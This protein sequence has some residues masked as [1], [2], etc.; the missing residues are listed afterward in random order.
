E[1]ETPVASGSGTLESDLRQL[2]RT[3]A[4]ASLSTFCLGYNTGIVAGAQAGLQQDP[5]FGVL[6][7]SLADGELV[8]CALLG[9]A[10]GAV[11]GQFANLV[12]RR[13]MLLAVAVVFLISPIAMALSPDFVSLLAARTMSGMSIGVSSVLV[14]LYITEVSPA[15]CRGRLGGWAPFIGTT[16]I[17]V[18]YVVSSLLGPLTYGAWR[19][20]FGLASVPA[21]CILILQGSIPET[22]RWL[23][24]QSRRGEA[25]ES[26]ARLFP[27]ASEESLE[28]ELQRIEAELSHSMQ[29]NS[30]S[31]IGL[32]KTHRMPTFIGMSINIL[33]QVSGIN[34]F[35]YFAPEIL[36]EA[37]FGN[38][39]MVMTTLISLLQ[40]TATAVLIRYIDKVGR[41]PLALGG[42]L[43]MLAGLAFLVV[44][45]L[46]R[47]SG[48]NRSLTAV[49]SL[50]GML[51]FRA[52]FSLSL[53]PLPYIM[54]SEFFP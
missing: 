53:G 41:R 10:V 14:N 18:S 39:S 49:G 25:K 21:L 19:W 47:G 42:L 44:A 2:Q 35:I 51:I 33:Q 40:L 45:D 6:N 31:T 8:S 23:L 46:L 54:T 26:M 13:R 36:A 50:L 17:L 7:T 22:P 38:K 5:A 4:A 15:A 20:Q 16:G 52:S 24:S 43:G 32:F 30:V 11:C 29:L 27:K 34:V 1:G 9:A 48:A 37:G 12:G 28:A 3:V